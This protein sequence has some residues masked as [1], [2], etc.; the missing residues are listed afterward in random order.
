MV[1]AQRAGE[2]P[3]PGEIVLGDDRAEEGRGLGHGGAKHR[4]SICRDERGDSCRSRPKVSVLVPAYQSRGTIGATLGALRRQT[5]APHEVLVVESSGDGAAEL[6]RREFPEA[7]LL[8]SEER[9][10]PGAARQLALPRVSGEVV[11]CLDADCTPEPEWLAGLAGAIEAGAAAVA[12]AVLNASD[13]TTT[14]WAYFL[15]EFAPSASRPEPGAARRAHLQHGLPG[16]G[17]H[18]G[19]RLSGPRSPFR[20]LPPAL[21]TARSAWARAS[22]SCPRPA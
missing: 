1:L 2:H 16:A 6:V 13:S 12:G 3:R 14:G 11:A 15:S 7:A 17:P 4:Y 20:R 5:R 19:G 10:F 9:L 8:V 22:S 21:A 18:G